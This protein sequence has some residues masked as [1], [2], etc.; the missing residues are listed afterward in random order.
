MIVRPDEAAEFTTA[1]RCAILELWNRASDE[2]VS[3][4]RARVAPGVA[5][6]WHCVEGTVERYVILQGEGLASVGEAPPQRVGP[7]DCVVIAAGERQ[8]IANAGDANLV[9]YCICTPRF[10][11]E[12]YRALE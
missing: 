9:F 6:Q 2:A 8:R 5:T 1:E 12:N 10:R 3:V 11:Q 7:G 4:A